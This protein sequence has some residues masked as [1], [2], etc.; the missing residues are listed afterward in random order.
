M[1]AKITFR[2]GKRIR[3]GR[4]P[5]GAYCQGDYAKDSDAELDPELADIVA[6]WRGVFATQKP[7]TQ[8]MR[9]TL[10]AL[11]ALDD[12]DIVRACRAVDPWTEAHLWRLPENPTPEEIREVAKAALRKMP[13]HDGRRNRQGNDVWFGVDLA[14]WWKTR[15]GKRPTV[16]LRSDMA[17]ESEFLAWATGMFHRA[18]RRSSGHKLIDSASIAKSLREARK[19]LDRLETSAE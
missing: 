18:G 17:Q 14:R 15:T 4:H 13:R 5:S 3:R 2:E 10:R 12:S 6:N 11:V 9:A 19:I 1:S 8:D 16:T 7:S